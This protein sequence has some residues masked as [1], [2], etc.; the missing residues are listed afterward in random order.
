[1]M[2]NVSEDEDRAMKQMGADNNACGPYTF[3]VSEQDFKNLNRINVV[4]SF[5]EYHMNKNP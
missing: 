5:C 2:E 1:M 3:M 4:H